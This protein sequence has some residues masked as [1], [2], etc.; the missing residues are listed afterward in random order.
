MRVIRLGGVLV[1]LG[2]LHASC[3][4]KSTSP[5]EAQSGG[6]TS[7][8]GETPTGPAPRSGTGPSTG[9]KQTSRGE[10]GDVT[11]AAGEPIASIGGHYEDL[12]GAG[13]TGT[14]GGT[15]GTDPV[16]GGAGGVPPECAT[17]HQ[18]GYCEYFDSG[19]CVVDDQVC[20]CDVAGIDRSGLDYFEWRC[21]PR[22]CPA[23]PPNEQLC[24]APTQNGPPH[25]CPYGDQTC[26]C[27]AEFGDIRVWNCRPTCPDITPVE[28]QPCI[29]SDSQHDCS[30]DTGT[31]HCAYVNP[32]STY[33]A[34]WTCSDQ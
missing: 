27:D 10:T 30:Y 13:G 26:T 2:L 14:S 18:K 31:C 3:G 32:G 20:I 9:G 29:A 5:P 22:A 4:G 21:Y 34:E 25:T 28:H 19:P 33:D 23:E 17:A 11:G 1:V 15:A 12:A 8:G 16:E 7:H 6:A 24:T